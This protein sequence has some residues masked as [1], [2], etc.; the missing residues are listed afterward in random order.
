MYEEIQKLKKLVHTL[1]DERTQ[2]RSKIIRYDSEIT[3]KV[4][5]KRDT[6]RMC[7]RDWGK[8]WW[9]VVASKKV[10]WLATSEISLRFWRR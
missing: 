5:A 9:H 7:E 10:V 1:S 2:L 4:R 3:R 8:W 6:E